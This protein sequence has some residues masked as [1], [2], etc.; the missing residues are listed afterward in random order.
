MD[1]A[2]VLTEL[3]AVLGPA[4]HLDVPLADM[5]P[6][7]TDP[8]DPFVQCVLACLGEGMSAPIGLP[9]FTDASV[10]QTAYG[11]CPT[12]ILGPGG[13]SQAHQT[14]EF[15]PVEKIAEAAL[16]YQRLIE[17]WCRP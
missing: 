17:R 3:K 11:G 12:V 5:A 13:A 10:L 14:D 9:Y 15:C 7:G 1:H 8:E 4:V 16:I 6:V 2:E